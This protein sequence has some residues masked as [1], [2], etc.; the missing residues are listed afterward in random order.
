MN[1]I[2]RYYF[3]LAEYKLRDFLYAAILTFLL[4]YLGDLCDNLSL[5]L[6]LSSSKTMLP[7]LTFL[8]TLHS[9]S[10]IFFANSNSDIITKLKD[11]YIW[12]KHTKTKIKKIIEIYSYFSWAIVVQFFSLLYTILLTLYIEPHVDNSNMHSIPIVLNCLFII[13]IFLCLYSVIL[14]LRNIGIFF[15][16]LIWQ[17]HDKDNSRF[18]N[19]INDIDEDKQCKW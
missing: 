6:L 1:N 7:I 16:V 15:L 5:K 3:T 2:I 12:I 13:L 11:E 10:L 18:S 14:C 4:F 17:P 8:A 19:D 9:S